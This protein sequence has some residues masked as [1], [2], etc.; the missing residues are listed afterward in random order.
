MEPKRRLRFSTYCGVGAVALL[1]VSLLP[2]SSLAGRYGSVQSPARPFGLD[3]VDRTQIRNSDSRARDFS[4]NAWPWMRSTMQQSGGVTQPVAG[5]T[6]LLDPGRL[7][8]LND[9]D[10]R[11]Y[12]LQDDA[13]YHNTLGFNPNGS[14]VTSDAML[15]FPD[16]SSNGGRRRTT[17]PLKARDFVDL[18]LVTGGSV[19]DFFVIADGANGGTNVFGLDQGAN[20]DGLQHVAIQARVDANSPYLLM[21]FEDTLG[22]GDNDMNDLVVAL[23]IGVANV[24]HILNTVGAPEPGSLAALAAFAALGGAARRRRARPRGQNRTLD[25]KSQGPNST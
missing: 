4:T 11:M 9:Y 6:V 12:F 5:Q 25:Q 8:L 20:P 16:A 13:G 7:E 24:Q 23:D 21:G 19:L 3:I 18:G 14:G 10:V 17:S 1:L 15:I 2:T 22:G